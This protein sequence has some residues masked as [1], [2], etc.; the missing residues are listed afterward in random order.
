MNKSIYHISK[1]DCPSEEQMIRM[2]LADLDSIARLEFDIAAR[3]LFVYHEGAPSEISQRLHALNLDTTLELTSEARLE[4]GEEDMSMQRRLLWQVLSIN[5][6]FFLVE[7][8]LG[9]WANSMGLVA[10][11]LDMFADALVYG[12]ALTAV[13]TS[14]TRQRNIA[15]WAGIFQIILAL[16]GM[17]EVIRRFISPE[18]SPN[19][20]W[21]I[22]VSFLALIGNGICLYL[23]QR[24]N[25]EAAHMK[26]SMIFTSN[27]VIVNLG[28]ILAAVLV[29]LTQSN[30]PDLVIGIIVFVLVLRGARSIMALAKD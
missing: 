20:F 21:M 5:F 30:L 15:K 26:A 18:L 14:L 8:G 23:L 28:V 25:S 13:G 2:K 12:M 7:I 9:F 19:V 22:L 24:S 27:D 17:I 10:D 1:M 29:Y 11:G 3:K 4:I 16:V 6:I